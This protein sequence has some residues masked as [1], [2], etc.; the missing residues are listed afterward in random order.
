MKGLLN[1]S[2][3]CDARPETYYFFNEKPSSELISVLLLERITELSPPPWWSHKK[4]CLINN[5]YYQFV[6]YVLDCPVSAST[7]INLLYIKLK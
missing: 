4:I 2:S 6:E 1:C 7:N 5:Q 3:Y